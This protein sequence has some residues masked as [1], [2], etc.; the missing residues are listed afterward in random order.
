MLS[1]ADMTHLFGE[2]I[3]AEYKDEYSNSYTATKNTKNRYTL[4]KK[5][6]YGNSYATVAKTKKQI[7]SYI[8][9]NKLNIIK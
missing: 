3:I 4:Y 5:A 9:D 7:V 1:F 8:I 6:V 2:T